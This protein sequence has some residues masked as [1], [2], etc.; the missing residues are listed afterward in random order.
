MEGFCHVHLSRQ[1]DD[2]FL[3]RQSNQ[4]HICEDSSHWK[5]WVIPV[6]PDGTLTFSWCRFQLISGVQVSKLIT[7]EYQPAKVQIIKT[8]RGQYRRN[9]FISRERRSSTLVGRW[10]SC[11]Q[12][13]PAV[14]G[15]WQVAWNRMVWLAHR[16]TYSQAL[17]SIDGIGS[18]SLTRYS[19]ANVI[20]IS[21]IHHSEISFCSFPT[22]DGFEEIA[23]YV[24]KRSQMLPRLVPKDWCQDLVPKRPT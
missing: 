22:V 16:Q 14:S 17:P 10:K 21:S 7:R 3:Q 18:R 5:F 13:I 11:L 23:N 6:F 9:R 12:Y 1:F 20:K 19:C 4:L 8:L 15:I 24:W 2:F